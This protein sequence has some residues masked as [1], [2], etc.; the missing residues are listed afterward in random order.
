MKSKEQAEI[1]DKIYP[2]IGLYSCI[3]LS[4]FFPFFLLWFLFPTLSAL[5]YAL[6]SYFWEELAYHSAISQVLMSFA[7][8]MTS[9][10]IER[11]RDSY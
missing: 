11:S 3:F 6:F 7:I 5:K 2:Q 4:T 8:Q 1:Y 10:A 9:E